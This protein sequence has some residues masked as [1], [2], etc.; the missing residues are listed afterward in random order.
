MARSVMSLTASATSRAK[1]LISDSGKFGI[2]LNRL[3]LVPGKVYFSV[4][5]LI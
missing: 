2:K 4:A 3:S 1:V 5:I